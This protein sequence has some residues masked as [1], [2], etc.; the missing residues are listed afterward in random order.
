[1][2][3]GRGADPLEG[4]TAVAV[5]EVITLVEVEEP[6]ISGRAMGTLAVA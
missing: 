5:V 3:E 2:S 1:M 4:T 6:Q